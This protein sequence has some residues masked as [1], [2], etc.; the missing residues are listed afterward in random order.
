MRAKSRWLSVTA[1]GTAC[2]V[3]KGVTM[4]VSSV[5]L[6]LFKSCRKSGDQLPKLFDNYCYTYLA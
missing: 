5:K 6:W 3:D 1:G 4:S 2:K